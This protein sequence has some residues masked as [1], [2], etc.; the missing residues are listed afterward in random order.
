MKRLLALLLS[1]L[2]LLGT[3]PALAADYPI[4]ERFYRQ[5]IESAYRGT[6]T[7]EVTGNG[8]RLMDDTAWG[9]LKA[10]APQLSIE[11][12][13]SLMRGEGQAD[14]TLLLEGSPAGKTILLYNDTLLGLSSDLLAGSGTYYTASRNWELK[15]LVKP[16]MQGESEWPPME[17]VVAAIET[18]PQEW[19]E[20]ASGYLSPYQLKLDIWMNGYASSS[21][22][23]VDNVPYAEF[24][25][26]IPAQA[27]KAE[28]KQLMVDFYADNQ[29]LA[30]L[31]ELLTAEE[32]AAYLQPS[33]QSQLFSMIDSL[34]LEGS[35]EITRRYDGKGNALLDQI[36]LPF[37]ENQRL[38][39]LTIALDA[40][41]GTPCLQV[42]GQTRS[43][44]DF[45]L[46]CTFDQA[47]GIYSGSVDISLPE[48]EN[49]SFVVSDQAA[50]RRSI[51]FDYN[52]S[53]D[54]GE[55]KYVLSTNRYE[56]ALEATLL[57]R[58][59][60]GDESM[61]TQS[62]ALK[63]SFSSSGNTQRSATQLNGSL[64][65]RDLDADASITATL[66]S[67]TAAPFA[68]TSL[69]QVTGALRVDLMNDAGRAALL[70]R[71]SVT[72]QEWLQK[73]ITSLMLSMTGTVPQ[74]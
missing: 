13:H 63:A 69:D 15:E 8:T 3:V 32:A 19:R 39:Y 64:T 20:R 66:A 16:L 49:A 51:A 18:A 60:E 25:Y 31:R 12:N 40:Q 58:P 55:E 10:I 26:S 47:E 65:W 72:S 9:L 56:R 57:L 44:V 28:I 61:P 52:F 37:A 45:A 30:L 59:R 74:G 34:R 23:L 50:N 54:L 5:M 6:V 53:L 17:R 1:A 67:R 21:A 71:W 41:K 27:L 29:L 68:V 70:Q 33:A 7:F 22:G 14:V 11:I 36:T 62:L 73:L 42:S 4:E 43:D 46:S 38:S 2:L 24:R 48:E 35:V